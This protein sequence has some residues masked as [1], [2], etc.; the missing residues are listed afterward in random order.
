MKLLGL[1]AYYHDS[2]AALLVDGR[3]MAAAQ[4]ERFIR[5]KHEAGFPAESIRFCLRQ[6]GIGLHELDG[7]VFYEKP[8]LKFDRLLETYVALAPRGAAHFVRSFPSWIKQKLFLR[9]EIGRELEKIGRFPNDILFSGHHLSHAASAFYPSPFSEA[10]AVTFDGVGEWATAAVARGEGPALTMLEEIH[11]PHSLGLFYSTFTAL[12]G[13][14]VNSGEY[15]V[16]GLAPYGRPRFKDLLLTK[17]LRLEDEGLFSLN[18]DY[19][20][21]L[22]GERMWSPALEALLG[23]V[24]RAPESEITPEHKDL[25]AS[26]QAA[27][28]AAVLHV[29]G[30]LSRKYP[31]EN[32]CLAG[33]VALNCVANSRLRAAGLFKEIWV[34]PAAGDAGGSL[35]AALAAHYQHF[36]GTRHVNGDQMRGALLGPGYLGSEVEAALRK[37]DLSYGRHSTPEL[38]ELTAEALAAGK[39]IGWFQ[40]RAEFGPRALGARSIL[41]DARDPGM[42][43]RLNLEVKFR[44]SFRPF[45]PVV[46]AEEAGDWFEW[47]GA[48]PYMLFVARV[49]DGAGI[50]AVTHVDGTARLQTVERGTHPLLHALLL[51]FKAR[52]GC[53]VLLNTSFNERGEPP[54]GSPEDAIRCFLATG[55]DMLVIENFVV[56]KK[57][58]PGPRR[59][60]AG[61]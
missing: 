6:A 38:L 53:P 44:E 9:Q 59:K 23:I 48:S 4:E 20:G 21:F 34:Q 16:M 10:L 32:L 55:L 3:I 14:R 33:G 31:A 51:A 41:A 7:I 40:G 43:K 42:Q 58:G 22:G 49:K 12:L 54:V 8:F 2:A 56:T 47:E 50:P 45:A 29:L 35:G 19:F 24:P 1:S 36:R 52:T 37:F 28:E 18:M 46:P 57:A 60:F 39:I 61:D 30:H 17:V 27:L 11:F 5:Q 25:A 13:F 26:A 15:K